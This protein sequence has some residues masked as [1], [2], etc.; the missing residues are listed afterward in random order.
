[1]KKATVLS[2]S[3]V[4]DDEQEGGSYV[5]PYVDMVLV[6]KKSDD[7]VPLHRHVMR[8]TT[9]LFR[10]F[11]AGQPDEGSPSQPLRIPVSLFTAYPMK[12]WARMVYTPSYHPW[13]ITYEQVREFYCLV[14][15][16]GCSTQIKNRTTEIILE[17]LVTRGGLGEIIGMADV[18]VKHGDSVSEKVIS[19][20]LH[21]ALHNMEAMDHSQGALTTMR[22]TCLDDAFG[23]R[24]ELYPATGYVTKSD[25]P[26]RE[27]AP[28]HPAYVDHHCGVTW[29]GI[30]RT[31]A[32]EL[33]RRD[34]HWY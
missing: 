31:A 5:D 2:P 6:M 22:P 14:Q 21:A 33:F 17:Y 11:L 25:V 15:W 10:D 13:L 29:S 16:L 30:R 27:D 24:C 23:W 26:P 18:I 32:R 7:E 20:L 3:A 34:Q 12:E 8:R 9:S 28:V 4:L 1:V 19:P